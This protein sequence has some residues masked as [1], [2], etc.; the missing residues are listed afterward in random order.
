[1]DAQTNSIV[2]TFIFNIK[3][4]KIL[5]SKFHRSKSTA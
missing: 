2:S 3:K 5:N 1:M 4:R